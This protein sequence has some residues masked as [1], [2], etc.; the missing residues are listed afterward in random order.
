MHTPQVIGPRGAGAGVGPRT[1]FTVRHVAPTSTTG[2]AFRA[3]LDGVSP[4][5]RK[6]RNM[7]REH[8]RSDR[9]ADAWAR[10]FSARCCGED[11]AMF[12]HPGGERGHART[13]RQRPAEAMCRDCVALDPCR[14]HFLAVGERFGT[15]GSRA[16]VEREPRFG[17]H[18]SR[19]N[20]LT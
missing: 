17:R 8:G 5:A 9:T 10:Q 18:R 14:R 3:L 7:T 16:E 1:G 2:D 20:T 4:S 12:F 11:P 13:L 6:E 19:K 15:C